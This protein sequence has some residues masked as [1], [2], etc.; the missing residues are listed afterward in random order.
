M[1]SLPTKSI[2]LVF[3]LF[4]SVSLCVAWPT[5]ITTP[6]SSSMPLRDDPQDV[7]DDTT[8]N[9]NTQH[10]TCT[11]TDE[12]GNYDIYIA[13]C[14]NNLPGTPP[15]YTWM[16]AHYAWKSNSG[17]SWTVYNVNDLSGISWPSGQKNEA[18][19]GTIASDNSNNIYFLVH[20][21]Y[22]GFEKDYQVLLKKAANAQ[23]DQ[24][25]A[26]PVWDSNQTQI[27][28]QSD[29]MPASFAV[30]ENGEYAVAATQWSWNP[31]CLYPPEENPVESGLQF[32]AWIVSH[33]VY[34]I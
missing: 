11:S 17:S 28:V 25:T 1:K 16:P 7:Y 19:W 32:R 22:E 23:P 29:I 10:I 2:F 31:A 26:Y 6:M 13:F 30:S 33:R 5:G 12:E 20:V 14:D 9:S 21:I 24:L 34:G 27:W 4:I 8:Q 3:F 18:G 15:P